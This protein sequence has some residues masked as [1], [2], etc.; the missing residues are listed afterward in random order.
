MKR[1]FFTSSWA[2]ALALVIGSG[3][4]L[5]ACGATPG[6]QPDDMSA[7]HHRQMAA[8]EDRKA[9]EHDAHFDPAEQATIKTAGTDAQGDVIYA[10]VVYNPTEVHLKIAGKHRKHAEDHRAAA[11]ALDK[12]EEQQCKSFPPETRKVCPLLGQLESVQDID[13]GVRVRFSKGVNMDAA[14]DH[15]LCHLAY[16]RTQGRQGMDSCPLY[17]K[18]V[19]AKRV[20]DSNDLDLTVE[21]EASVRGLR[22]RAATHVTPE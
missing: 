12:F 14:T 7:D 4:L 19:A 8:E 3:V 16:G 10:P 21:D 5:G 2:S 15:V 6:A 20:G 13:G 18:G 1:K 22:A 9:R 17:I 11:E